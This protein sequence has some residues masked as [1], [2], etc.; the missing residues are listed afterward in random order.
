[1]PIQIGIVLFLA[2]VLMMSA[3]QA[4]SPEQRAIA[5]YRD[6]TVAAFRERVDQVNERQPDRPATKREIRSNHL[7]WG[8]R[9]NR[10]GLGRPF[11]A[12]F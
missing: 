10:H 6:C 3:A 12:E 4:Q 8:P 1:M 9:L 11:Q 7:S 5:A 2:F